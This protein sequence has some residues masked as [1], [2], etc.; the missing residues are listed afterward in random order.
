MQ[1]GENRCEREIV[2]DPDTD[3]VTGILDRQ[4]QQR[5]IGLRGLNKHNLDGQV[6][7][8]QEGDHLSNEANEVNGILFRHDATCHAN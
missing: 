2:G 1:S 3:R 8:F 5:K 7:S 4:Q 6:I